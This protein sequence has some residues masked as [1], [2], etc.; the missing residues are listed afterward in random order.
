MSNKLD[1]IIKKVD[2]LANMVEILSRK[3]VDCKKERYNGMG[4]CYN[5]KNKQICEINDELQKLG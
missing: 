4:D 1:V 2:L 3:I 5:C